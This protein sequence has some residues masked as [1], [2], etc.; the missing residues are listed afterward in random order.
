MNSPVHLSTVAA[1]G[2]LCWTTVDCTGSAGRT[3]WLWSA[4]AATG[5][6]VMTTSG[7][8]RRAEDLSHQI[9]L[10]TDCCYWKTVPASTDSPSS[11]TRS[12]AIHL[13][14]LYN[15]QATFKRQ[16]K[17]YMFVRYGCQNVLSALE[18]FYE[19]TGG[20]PSAKTAKRWSSP[21][22]PSTLLAFPL[23][24]S[25]PLEVRPP[26]FPLNGLEKRCEL[27]SRVWS[28]APDKIKLYANYSIKIWDLVVTIL[29][30]IPSLEY[31]FLSQKIRLREEGWALGLVPPGG[32]R[33]CYCCVSASSLELNSW[34]RA[35]LRTY[36]ADES[37]NKSVC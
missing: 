5:P 26:E 3:I 27:P 11:N 32:L 20:A 37:Q 25:V 36:I 30:I 9:H 23:S 35:T 7:A 24:L 29:I 13:P 1:A 6:V 19:Q 28:R 10:Y 12:S 2:W 18:I 22:L 14:T 34:A 16:L 8:Q 33:H 4:G 31:L 15:I 21:S 17:T